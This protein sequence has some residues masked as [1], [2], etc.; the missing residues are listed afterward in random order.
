MGRKPQKPR[1]YVP[2][3]FADA[4]VDPKHTSHNSMRREMQSGFDALAEVFAT[5][6]VMVPCWV[7]WADDGERIEIQEWWNSESDKLATLARLKELFRLR[8]VKRYTFTSEM[9]LTSDWRVRAPTMGSHVNSVCVVGVDRHGARIGVGCFEGNA[10]KVSRIGGPFYCDG[11][12]TR[13]LP[14]AHALG[15]EHALEG[16]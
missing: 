11:R 10:T 4:T 6:D 15:V 3:A 13:L 16:A 9:E 12:I 1:S 5:G 8:R 14:T 7:A 2:M